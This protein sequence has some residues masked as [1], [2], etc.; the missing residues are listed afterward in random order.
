MKKQKFY[1]IMVLGLTLVM[2]LSA[3]AFAVESRASEYL[4]FFSATVTET[5]DG[6]L[7]VSCTVTGSKEMDSIGVNRIE[8]QWY[9]GSRW[10]VEKVYTSRELLDLQASNDMYVSG[11]LIHTPEKSGPYRALVTVYA[12]DGK[13]SDSR[14]ITTRS[15]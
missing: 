14:V 15:V 13:G 4:S 2:L 11:K 10:A 3:T 12:K 9:N 8:I 5:G 6:D 7:A 1:R